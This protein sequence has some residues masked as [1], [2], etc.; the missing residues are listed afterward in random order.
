MIGRSTQLIMPRSFLPV[1]SIGCAA[2]SSR[3]LVKFGPA[4]VVLGDPLAGELAGLDLA[5][6]LASSPP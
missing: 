4:G 3:H 5:E 2:P 1:S 6:D